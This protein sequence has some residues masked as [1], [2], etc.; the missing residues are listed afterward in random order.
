MR[1]SS[2]KQISS[3]GVVLP[4]DYGLT[5]P[6]KIM[7]LVI[8][9]NKSGN[10]LRTIIEKKTFN[11]DGNEVSDVESCELVFIRRNYDGSE[12]FYLVT[13]FSLSELDSLSKFIKGQKGGILL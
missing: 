10:E 2:K 1:A 4:F 3:L 9:S 11:F 13:T 12:L 6:P 7:P 8:F 5:N